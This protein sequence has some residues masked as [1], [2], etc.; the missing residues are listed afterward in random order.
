MSPYLDLPCRSLAEVLRETPDWDEA[1]YRWG[2]QDGL[3]GEEWPEFLP[4]PSYFAG[5][6]AGRAL[7]KLAA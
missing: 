5:R 7:R 3:H 1:D 4:P 6:Q 2:Y